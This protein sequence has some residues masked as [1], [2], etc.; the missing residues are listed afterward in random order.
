MY[1]ITGPKKEI[2]RIKS[3]MA[4]DEGVVSIVRFKDKA[5]SPDGTY[6]MEPFAYLVIVFVGHLAAAVAHDQIKYLIER[7]LEG[8]RNVRVDEEQKTDED[9]DADLL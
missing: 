7:Y 6:G 2:E 8:K 9:D 3:E 1:R 4:H 5:T